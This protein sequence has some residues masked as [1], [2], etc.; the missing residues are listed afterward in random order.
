MVGREPK[1][2]TILRSQDNARGP[3]RDR[4]PRRVRC[5]RRR[6]PVTFL[7]TR[8]SVTTGTRGGQE[9]TRVATLPD[10]AGLVNPIAPT[11]PMNH[12]DGPRHRP[13]AENPAQRLRPRPVATETTP[14]AP[15]AFNSSSST[16]S[17]K[18]PGIPIE[19]VVQ[20]LPRSDQLQGRRVTERVGS[21]DLSSADGILGDLS[22]PPVAR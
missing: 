11:A 8:P 12:R 4:S 9:P 20:H 5:H 17:P 16:V 10:S 21:P 1:D 3:R 15:T 7:H 6:S 14:G 19:C 13:A 22:D 18:G 2:P